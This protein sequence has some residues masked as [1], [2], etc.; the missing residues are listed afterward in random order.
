[1]LKLQLDGFPIE[2][3]ERKKP[4]YINREKTH[5]NSFV[6]RNCAIQNGFCD[7][8]DPLIPEIHQSH[9]FVV[10]VT[11]AGQSIYVGG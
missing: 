11:L 5:E 8:E 10:S 3:I 1:M 9:G 6:S 7:T 2:D 4:G